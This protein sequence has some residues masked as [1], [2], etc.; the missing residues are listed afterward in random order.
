M[1]KILINVCFFYNGIFYILDLLG[2]KTELTSTRRIRASDGCDFNKIFGYYEA[3]TFS[4][5]IMLFNIRNKVYESMLI[6]VDFCQWLWQV[7][8]FFQVLRYLPPIKKTD[9]HDIQ[10]CWLALNTIN[11]PFPYRSWYHPRLPYI[12][13]QGKAVIFFSFFFFFINIT[14]D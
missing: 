13:P 4:M 14:Y 3:I 7:G 6:P 5:A 1:R 10:Y 8:V 11:L 2:N 9:R 12:K